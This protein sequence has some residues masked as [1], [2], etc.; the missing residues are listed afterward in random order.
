MAIV[1]GHLAISVCLHSTLTS[2]EFF[3]SATEGNEDD[4]VASQDKSLAGGPKLPQ[5]NSLTGGPE[6]SLLSLVRKSKSFYLKSEN[7]FFF[8]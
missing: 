7:M 3:V 6:L 5:D 1:S 8:S 4:L 2:P